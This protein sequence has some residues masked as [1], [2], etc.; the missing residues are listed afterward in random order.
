M[1]TDASPLPKQAT[2]DVETS[3]SLFARAKTTSAPLAAAPVPLGGYKMTSGGGSSCRFSVAML[4]AAT[5]AT[6]AVA[7][8][9]SDGSNC[10]SDGATLG[11]PRERRE[12]RP[13]VALGQERRDVAYLH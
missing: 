1:N 12:D 4:R 7:G 3:I 2:D 6:A 11:G 13:L 10:L 9:A 5:L 8:T